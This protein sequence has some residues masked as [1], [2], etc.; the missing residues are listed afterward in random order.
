MLCL[1]ESKFQDTFQAAGM[2]PGTIMSRPY[3][4]CDAL[5][6]MVMVLD[7]PGTSTL[8]YI[9]LLKTE[10]VFQHPDDRFTELVLSL[11]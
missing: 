11:C 9:A 7:F 5:H 4:P 8:H 1:F 10:R 6:R 3:I 2:N